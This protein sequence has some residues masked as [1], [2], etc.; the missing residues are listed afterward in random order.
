MDQD[1][2]PP[3]KKLVLGLVTLLAIWVGAF[4]TTS[5]LAEAPGNSGDAQACQNEGWQTLQTSA[6]SLF[7][8]QGQCV[9]YAAQGGLLVA[10]P[11]L[12]VTATI[13]FCGGPDPYCWGAFIGTGLAPLSAVYLNYTF[14]D[15]SYQ[16]VRYADATGNISST[17]PAGWLPGEGIFVCGG[18]VSNVYA[19]GTTASGEGITSNVI[20]SSPC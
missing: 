1:T 14:A 17:G 19:T 6:G 7:A 13:G 15:A 16:I 12:I 9:S 20:A 3:H 8:N 10:R 18:V 2:A 5:A 11:S 4:A